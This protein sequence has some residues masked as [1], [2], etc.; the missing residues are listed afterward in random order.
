MWQYNHVLEPAA[1]DELKHY[2]VLGMKWGVRRDRKRASKATTKEEKSKVASSLNKNREKAT[3][4]ISKLEKQEQKLTKR[5]SEQVRKGEVKARE[6]KNQAAQT[7]NKAYGFLVSQK[8]S[9]K[10]LYEA[11]KLDAQA[12]AILARARETQARLDKN[13]EMQ[14]IFNQG[15]ND[16]DQTLVSLGRE[17]VNGSRRKSA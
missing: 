12:D 11:A 9:E 6:L 2:G 17:Y 13:R 3:K 8:K 5:R 15:I 7:R 4:K 14:K 16:I 1:S 10:R